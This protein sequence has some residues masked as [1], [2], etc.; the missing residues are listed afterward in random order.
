MSGTTTTTPGQITDPFRNFNFRISIADPQGEAH[1][2]E[3]FGLGVRIHTIR[4]REAG[5]NQEVRA[6]PGAVEYPDV[7]LRYGLTG[8]SAVWNWLLSAVTGVPQGGLPIRRNV[9]IYALQPNGSDD[10]MHW[11]LY[12]AFPSEWTGAAF[13]A[14]GRGAAIAEL[15]LAYDKAVQV[16]P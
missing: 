9:S 11:D 13:D 1:F 14:M 15:R 10:G 4:Y 2:T 12:N 8:S 7:T 3:C 6:I 5:R 16:I